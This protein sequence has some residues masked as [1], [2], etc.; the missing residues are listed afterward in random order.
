MLFV[1]VYI[2][3]FPVEF[4]FK[5][6]A[7]ADALLLPEN[8]MVMEYELPKLVAPSIVNV[9]PAVILNAVLPGFVKVIVLLAEFGTNVTDAEFL[10]V[11]PFNVVGGFVLTETVALLLKTSESPVA[12]TPDGDQLPLVFQL[13]ELPLFHVLVVCA[14]LRCVSVLAN[15]T[16][17]IESIRIPVY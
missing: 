17:S 9:L 7:M 3:L 13:P 10:I 15:N 11:I 12:G 8:A 4:T 1:A 16:S 2:P 6:P 5:V 14:K